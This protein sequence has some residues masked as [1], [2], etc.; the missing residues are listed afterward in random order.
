MR[1]FSV[2]ALVFKVT[3][4]SV[5]SGGVGG[6]LWLR[7]Q[8]ALAL[9]VGVLGVGFVAWRMRRWARRLVGGDEPSAAV[10]RV[11]EERVW[12][13]KRLSPT[14][15]ARFRREVRWFLMD[16]NIIGVKVQVDDELRA[17]VAASAVTLSFGLPAW[18][19]EPT[20]DILLYPSAYT[21]DYEHSS[22]KGTRLGQVGHQGPIIFSAPALRAGFSDTKDGHNVGLH[23]FAHVIDLEDGA[24]DGAPAHLDW[25]SVGPWVE[26]MR[27][28]LLRAERE[29]R[30][31]KVLRQ[32]GY[33]NEAE[34][35]ACATE[36]FFEQPRAL[37]ARAPELYA[38]MAEFYG[39]D[40]VVG[41]EAA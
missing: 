16:H 12:F 21:E 27:G 31:A 41:G 29:E 24:A 5:V 34:F 11:L 36:M 9:A 39:Q 23:E 38:L 37:K 17:L 1:R 20:R 14:E 22:R 6:L 15:K 40:F 2:S 13:Y 25:P 8:R 10:R 26:Q 30:R 32:Y 7:D 19:W 28:H 18:E 3:A 33:T 35:F 4:A